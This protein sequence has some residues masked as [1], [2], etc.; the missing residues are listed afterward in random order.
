MRYTAE[1]QPPAPRPK[2]SFR[3]KKK[4]ES[5]LDQSSDDSIV[6]IRKSRPLP[7]TQAGD[8]SK[9]PFRPVKKSSSSSKDKEIL[10]PCKSPSKRSPKKPRYDEED[11]DAELIP[12]SQSD[13]QELALPKM[14]KKDH[15]EIKES[16]NKWRQG[17][18]LNVPSIPDEWAMDVDEDENVVDPHLTNV[19]VSNRSSPL[20][21][22][23]DEVC[24]GLASSGNSTVPTTPASPAPFTSRSK[25]P[26]HSGV[27]AGFHLPLP[28]TPVA[29][30]TESKT[31]QIIAQIKARALAAT[32]SSHDGSYSQ[33]VFKELSDSSSEEEE[34][35]LDIWP[36][37]KANQGMGKRYGPTLTF[38]TFFR[39]NI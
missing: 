26:P 7:P 37:K 28:V 35:F 18:L 10:I 29:H 36:I 33:L 21:T 34:D 2:S 19:T 22:S 31:A 13:E 5:D 25:T 27:E 16:V 30:N 39:R 23:E 32:D 14:T 17:A 24:D 11:T 15:E 9:S 8:I 38:S 12:S 20:Q 3:H 6:L 1:M 4:I